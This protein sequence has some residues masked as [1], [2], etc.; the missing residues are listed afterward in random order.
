VPAKAALGRYT[1]R[2]DAGLEAEH[3]RQE[4]LA[5][6]GRM[7]VC[8]RHINCENHARGVTDIIAKADTLPASLSII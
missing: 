2:I 7:N 8:S 5:R 3:L 1:W 6:R 4:F